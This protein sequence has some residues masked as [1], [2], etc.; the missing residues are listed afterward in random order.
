MLADPA[1]AEVIVVDDGSVD[2]TPARLAELAAREP[3]RVRSARTPGVG[4]APAR[5]RG[6]ELAR[7]EVVLFF[8]DDLVAGEG[9]VAGHLAHHDGEAQGDPGGRSKLVLAGYSPV[10]LPPQR[11]RTLRLIAQLYA[12]EYE[13]E[14]E[15]WETG[16]AEVLMG[17]YGGHVSLRTD[18]A[19]EVG[20]LNPAFRE[21]FHEDRDFG[22]R[23][24]AAGLEGHFDRSL[25][26]PH[27]Y[28]R[29]L[30][31]FERG[32]ERLGAG[33]ARIH[34][35]YPELLGPFDEAMLWEGLPTAARLTVHTSRS[36][37]ARV[38]LKATL[39]V[40]VSH[41]PGGTGSPGRI[42]ALK[43]LRRVAMARGARRAGG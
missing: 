39:Q 35:L 1:T 9:L 5:Q 20:L 36:E 41:A 23:C 22:L 28:R 8:E 3:E 25:R 12:V 30:A 13:R 43:T 32:A 31:A 15:H 11:E 26:A 14:C 34:E 29:D 38:A 16:A 40:Y 21:T 10:V 18:R 2:G 19:R 17:L 33:L 7:S 6:L 42:A 24:R 37:P 4:P 27:H